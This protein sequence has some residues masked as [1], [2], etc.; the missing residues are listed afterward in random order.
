[1]L[2]G[3]DKI[4]EEKI[5]AAQK[6]GRFDRLPGEGKPLDIPEDGHIP[7]D[8]RLAYKILKNADCLPPEIELKKEIL[9]TEELLEGMKDELQR[10]KT[11]KKLNYLIMKL[12]TARKTMV[13]FETPER[14]EPEIVS[15]LSGSKPSDSKTSNLKIYGKTP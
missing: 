10:Y 5:L 6:R 14:Y 13:P 2:H 15:K 3:F 7:E 4:V 8:L 9:K 1:M 12:N 11:M